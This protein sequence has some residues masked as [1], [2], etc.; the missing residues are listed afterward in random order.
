MKLSGTWESVK[1]QW[2]RKTL[3]LYR[4]SANGRVTSV[5]VG[6]TEYELTDAVPQLPLEDEFRRHYLK[7]VKLVDINVA[8]DRRPNVR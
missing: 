4:L 3:L 5:G 1:L 2:P 6:E 7:A 8:P